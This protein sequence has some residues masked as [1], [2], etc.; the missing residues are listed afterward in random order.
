MGTVYLGEMQCRNGIFLDKNKKISKQSDGFLFRIFQLK[1]LIGATNKGVPRNIRQFLLGFEDRQ[2]S[3]SRYRILVFRFLKI[4]LAVPS[5][6]GYYFMID[7]DCAYRFR[8][9]PEWEEVGV[10]FKS[11]KFLKKSKN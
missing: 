9:S 5:G 11:R 6:S 3:L 10:N 2:S 1:L 8:P 4:C 7:Q